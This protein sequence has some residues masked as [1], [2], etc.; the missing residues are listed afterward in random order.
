MANLR[1]RGGLMAY[2]GAHMSTNRQKVIAAAA[3]AL[4]VPLGI[5]LLLYAMGMVPAPG[6][7]GNPPFNMSDRIST[8][9]VVED[10]QGELVAYFAGWDGKIESLTSDEFFQQVHERQVDLPWLFRRMDVTSTTSLLWVLFGFLAQGIFAGRMIVQWYASEKAK[11]SVIPN[12]FWWMS[13]IGSSMCIIY[14]IW[15]K[16]PVGVT[17]QATGWLVYVRNLWMI[18]GKNNSEQA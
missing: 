3:V 15:R 16:D 9:K 10:E 11:S 12:I 1:G 18:Y 5:W 14:F 2:G 8:I 17:G 4:L 7:P 6:K 13:L